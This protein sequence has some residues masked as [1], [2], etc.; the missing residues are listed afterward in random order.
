MYVAVLWLSVA[1]VTLT[2]KPFDKISKS[3]AADSASPAL[4]Q[5][6]YIEETLKVF[7]AE[8][9]RAHV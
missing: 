2:L 9:G 7:L 8:I 6:A 5:S 4:G 3:Y 1:D